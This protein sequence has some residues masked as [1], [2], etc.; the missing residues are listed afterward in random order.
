MSAFNIPMSAECK[1]DGKG[2]AVLPM[3][4]RFGTLCHAPTECFCQAP[5]EPLTH[6]LFTGPLQRTMALIFYGLV[7]TVQD[8]I[9]HKPGSHQPAPRNR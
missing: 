5:E 8:M 4:S 7:C 6:R 3:E 2:S 1:F 9:T